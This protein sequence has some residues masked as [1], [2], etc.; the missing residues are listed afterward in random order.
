MILDRE[1]VNYIEAP[2]VALLG[3]NGSRST[4][5]G[6][7]WYYFE[8]EINYP[9]TVLDTDYLNR[10]DLD[11]FDVLIIP[12]GFYSF[13][14]PIMK[15]MSDWVS[16]GGKLIVMER[17]LS[18][19][20]NKDGFGLKNYATDEEK[21]KAEDSEKED[22]FRR[23]EDRE[24]EAMKENIPGAIYKIQM[25]ESHP[26]AFG[27]GKNYYTLKNSTSR[28]AYLERG[29]NVGVMKENVKPV[30]GFAGSVANKGLSE[31]LIF[32]VFNKGRGEIVYMADNP[33]F[34]SFWENGKLLFT[35]AVFMVGQ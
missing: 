10:V 14:E 30:N 4:S 31:S 29:W 23:Y 33:I 2:K 12:N 13:R 1:N 17:A 22:P 28:Y 8:Q 26:L 5:F 9:V 34:R 35:N 18:A 11:D 7:V 3:G 24:R 20:V 25:D 32:G 16:S 6:E 19:F 27:Y 21:K 15:S